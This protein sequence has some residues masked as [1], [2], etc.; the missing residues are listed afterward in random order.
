VYSYNSVEPGMRVCAKGH[1][2]VTHL[3]HQF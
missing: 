1:L 3:L 2:L